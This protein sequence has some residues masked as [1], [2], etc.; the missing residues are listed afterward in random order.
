MI[1]VEREYSDRP[2]HA[3]YKG[4]DPPLIPESSK[5]ITEKIKLAKN[6]LPLFDSWTRPSKIQG[7]NVLYYAKNMGKR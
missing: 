1:Y 2:N 4:R 6:I 7:M 5:S 3:P